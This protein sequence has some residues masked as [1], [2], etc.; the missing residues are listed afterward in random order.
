MKPTRF[1]TLTLLMCLS[2]LFVQ[3]GPSWND[4]DKKIAEGDEAGAAVI[5]EQLA[6]KGDTSAIDWLADYYMNQLMATNDLEKTS[7][8]LLEKAEK[9]FPQVAEKRDGFEMAKALCYIYQKNDDKENLQKWT[10]IASEKGEP[11]SMYEMAKQYADSTSSRFNMKK[12]ATLYQKASDAGVEG[13]SYQL[14][15]MYDKGIYFPKD[16]AKASAYCEKA[17]NQ[18]DTGACYIMAFKYMYGE[19]VKVDYDKAYRYISRVPD[20]ECPDMELKENITKIHEADLKMQE[21]K[22]RMDAI[23]A[24]QSTLA[25]SRWCFND[26]PGVAQQLIFK[27]SKKVIYT[28]SDL[29]RSK[30]VEVALSFVVRDDVFETMTPHLIFTRILDINTPS[31]DGSYSPQWAYENFNE[32]GITLYINGNSM[33]V[34]GNNLMA[35]TY[36]KRE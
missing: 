19:G 33:R 5:L 25:N 6:E 24:I 29:Y 30:S 13:A 34:V 21:A 4:A 10:E 15:T 26:G 32:S 3:C 9:Y 22:R 12:A 11:W 14:Y 36:N 31:T 27:G 17:A 2:L 23:N 8:E 20:N 28:R 7:P 1:I 35:G 18:G 16:E